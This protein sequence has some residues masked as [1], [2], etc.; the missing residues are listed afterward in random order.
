MQNAS[1]SRL[2]RPARKRIQQVFPFVRYELGGI[3]QVSIKLCAAALHGAR[4][5]FSIIL[6]NRTE[7]ARKNGDRQTIVRG[8]VLHKIAFQL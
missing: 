4:P 3:D 6:N 2:P 5:R 7:K 1:S 8:L